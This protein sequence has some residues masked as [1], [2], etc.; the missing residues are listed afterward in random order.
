MYIYACDDW[1]APQG[2]PRTNAGTPR[3]HSDATQ[4]ASRTNSDATGTEW[5]AMQAASR[6]AARETERLVNSYRGAG[7]S[8]M[9]P[10]SSRAG[11]VSHGLGADSYDTAPRAD[12]GYERAP[13]AQAP[14]SQG[15]PAFSP[16][17]LVTC[18]LC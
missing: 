6:E 8:E 16:C 9:A 18:A 7:P 15:V 3:T 2:T 12:S 4:D 14:A 5:D 17:V 1:D 11:T 13:R 10:I